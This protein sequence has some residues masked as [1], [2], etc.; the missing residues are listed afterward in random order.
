[1]NTAF[2]IEAKVQ[3]NLEAPV[4]DKPVAQVLL[5][6]KI[7]WVQCRSCLGRGTYLFGTEVEKCH[8]CHHTGYIP[9]AETQKLVTFCR[10]WG[11]L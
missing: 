4:L 6:H 10:D 11:H 2:K 8:A 9:D 3:F 5:G 1:M 7:G